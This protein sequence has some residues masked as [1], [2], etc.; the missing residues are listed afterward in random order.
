MAS[1]MEENSLRLGAKNFNL[2]RHLRQC[3]AMILYF[4]FHFARS[5]TAV[6]LYNPI[7]VTGPNNYIDIGRCLSL[8]AACR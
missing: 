1:E 8:N 3:S 6:L 2:Q 7:H 5:S 4:L